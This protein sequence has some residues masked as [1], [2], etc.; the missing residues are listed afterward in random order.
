MLYFEAVTTIMVGILGLTASPDLYTSFDT[1]LRARQLIFRGR[2]MEF[3]KRNISA[4]QNYPPF[5]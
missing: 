5:T 4:L 1:L 3:P 2:A